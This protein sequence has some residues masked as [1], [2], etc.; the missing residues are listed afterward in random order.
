M[1]CVLQ[2]P[3]FKEIKMSVAYKMPN[4]L[5][6]MLNS[7]NLTSNVAK[8][9]AAN[10]VAVK[11]L[12]GNAGWHNYDDI[13]TLEGLGGEYLWAENLFASKIR[14]TF[15]AGKV[16][17]EGTYTIKD[18]LGNITE[19][20]KFN[21]VPNNPA[22]GWAFIGLQPNSGNNIR[23]FIVNGMMTDANWKIITLLLNKVNDQGPV[24]PAFSCVRMTD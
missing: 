13:Q 20:G 7:C 17:S 22:I 19:E 23:S 18:L 9:K 2:P 4:N 3:F 11:F 12:T 6:N 24:Y 8:L 21:C 15:D 5:D 14:F 10:D 1:V 16:G